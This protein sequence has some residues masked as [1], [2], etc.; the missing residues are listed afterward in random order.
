MGVETC[1][2]IKVISLPAHRFGRAKV[3]GLGDLEMSK[4]DV[5]R[6]LDFSGSPIYSLE[7]S[8]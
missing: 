2:G 3:E 1:S 7:I 4:V 6:S 8:N 5:F